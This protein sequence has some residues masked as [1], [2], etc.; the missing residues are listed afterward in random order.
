[1]DGGGG[2]A[3]EQTD[4]RTEGWPRVLG[5]DGEGASR[6]AGS[7]GCPAERTAVCSRGWPA[8]PGCTVLGCRWEHTI[9]RARFYLWH[10]Y[11]E[12]S[13]NREVIGADTSRVTTW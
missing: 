8:R 13:S 9:G 7:E 12:G 2:G 10:R 11:E 6:E 5:G 3:G 1:M 4:V